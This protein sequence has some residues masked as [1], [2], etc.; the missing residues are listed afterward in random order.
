M[1]DSILDVR[2]VR[3]GVRDR[4]GP[5]TVGM[6]DNINE[7]DGFFE[8]DERERKLRSILV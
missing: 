2:E 8:L 6:D 4:F 1:S 5:S 7:F 3:G